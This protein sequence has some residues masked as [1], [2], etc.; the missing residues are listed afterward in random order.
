MSS[1]WKLD[2]ARLEHAASFGES[3]VKLLDMREPP[4]DPFAVIEG[5][6][7]QIRAYGDDF[8]DVFFGLGDRHEWF[9]RRESGWQF[10][11]R[12]AT[13]CVYPN[14]DADAPLE[15]KDA[16]LAAVAYQSGHYCTLTVNLANRG[17]YD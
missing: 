9:K 14:I 10:D 12:E 5:E 4:I 8:G 11:G 15:R 3:V 7:G 13:V 16:L 1:N 2:Q 17:D 6:A